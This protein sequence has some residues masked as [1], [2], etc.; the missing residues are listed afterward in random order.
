VI[1]LKQQHYGSEHPETAKTLIEF[2]NICE[3]LGSLEQAEASLRAAFAIFRNSFGPQ[4]PRSTACLKHLMELQEKLRK[5][6][7][8]VKTDI[9]WT[10]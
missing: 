2:A 1:A 9:L 5:K 10:G 8:A 3:E 6:N 4:D 7:E